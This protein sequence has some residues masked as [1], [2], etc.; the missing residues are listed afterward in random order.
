MIETRYNV[1]LEIRNLSEEKYDE[2]YAF[3]EHT[4]IEYKIQN[5]SDFEIDTRSE[6]QKYDD[7]LWALGERQ[8]EEKRMRE[9]ENNMN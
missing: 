4:G 3:L 7:W 1:D 6:Q 9:L 2:L 8:Y 5:E